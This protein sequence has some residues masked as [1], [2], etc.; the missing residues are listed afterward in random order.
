MD[1][2]F[3]PNGMI[4][5]FGTS[6][7]YGVWFFREW[8]LDRDPYLICFHH[9]HPPNF[10][11]FWSPRPGWKFQ[12]LSPAAVGHL[13]VG[14]APVPV[15]ALS[16]TATVCSNDRGAGGDIS[17]Q[18]SMSVFHVNLSGCISLSIYI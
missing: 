8:L 5:V 17:K 6:G 13:A 14:R 7:V 15:A 9:F 2:H 3:P 1:H 12:D 16:A 18:T 4:F 10:Y 11:R